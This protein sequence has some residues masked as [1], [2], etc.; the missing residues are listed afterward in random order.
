MKPVCHS[1]ITDDDLSLDVIQNNNCQYFI[2][3]VLTN[4]K[5]NNGGINN[6]SNLKNTNII[7]YSVEKITICKQTYLSFYNQVSQCLVN[8]IKN[9]PVDEK[10]EIDLDLQRNNYFIN[11]DETNEFPDH[12]IIDTICDLFSNMEG[13]QVL[14]I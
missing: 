13:F 6:T 10:K 9:L 1:V 14:K 11:L 3:T 5:T 7:K 8:I 4:C 2:E 12:N